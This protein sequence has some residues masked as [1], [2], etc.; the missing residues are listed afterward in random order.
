MRYTVLAF[1]SCLILG[2]ATTRLPP[3]SQ[4]FRLEDD[5][6]RLWLRSEEEEKALGRSGMVYR[7]E[8]LDLY[9][10]EV[11]KR[12]VPPEIF[13]SI[14][15]KIVVIKSPLLNAFTYPNGVIYAHTG[16]LARMDNRGSACYPSRP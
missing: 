15:F 10:N 4:N 12:L 13:G 9:L 5:E 11:A 1:I 16:L 6:R 7:D 3:V 8:E 14:P 2:C